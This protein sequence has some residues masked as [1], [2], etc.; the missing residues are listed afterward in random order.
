MDECGKH[1]TKWKKL[2]CK[3]GNREVIA[4]ALGCLGDEENLLKWCGDS[5]HI[6]MNVLKHTELY[7]SDG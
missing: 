6:T 7:T 5:L 2:N 4:K 1:Y 3:M